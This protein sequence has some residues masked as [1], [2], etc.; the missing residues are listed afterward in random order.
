M[1]PLRSAASPIHRL[2]DHDRE[3]PMLAKVNCCALS[4][5]DCVG[6]D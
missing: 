4:G 6:E 2:L 1:L 3:S 5:I